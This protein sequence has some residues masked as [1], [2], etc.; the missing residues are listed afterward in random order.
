MT[1]NLIE[2]PMTSLKTGQQASHPGLASVWE[3][4][5]VDMRWRVGRQGA[6][7]RGTLF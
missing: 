5:K 1:K 2:R 6:G 7:E 3:A 4:R